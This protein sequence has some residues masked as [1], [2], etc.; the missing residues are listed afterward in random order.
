MKTREERIAQQNKMLAL[1]PKVQEEMC[2][3]YDT[4]VDV[5]IALKKTSGNFLEEICWMVVVSEKKE[6]RDLSPSELIPD[7]IY[8]FRTDV[9]KLQK[10]QPLSDP[11]PA[12]FVAP[13]GLN[14]P[15]KK[16]GNE[17]RPLLGGIQITSNKA[18]PT[19]AQRVAA[20]AAGIPSP[21]V[22]FGTLGCIAIL[23]TDNTPVILTNHHVC[24]P[25]DQ[26]AV[27]DSGGADKLGQPS[28]PRE[29][30]CCCQADYVATIINGTRSL[31]QN[32][33][34][35]GAVGLDAAIARLKG[36]PTGEKVPYTNEIRSIGHL[37]GSN[38]NF[39]VGD[40]VYKHGRKTGYEV[41]YIFCLGLNAITDDSSAI[42]NQYSLPLQIGI[43]APDGEIFSA[44]G[45]SGSV[46]VNEDN[47][48]I[49][50]LHGINSETAVGS[51]HITI[52][53]PIRAVLDFFDITIPTVG[54]QNYIPNSATDVLEPENI[55]SEPVLEGSLSEAF[56][57][58]T[59]TLNETNQGK[60]FIH[61]FTTVKEEILTLINWNREVKVVWNRA[62][63]PAYVGHFIKSLRDGRHRIPKKIG[64]ID[65]TAVFIKSLRV[66]ENHGS[67]F[68]KKGIE[69]KAMSLLEIVQKS[70][71]AEEFLNH[72][73]TQF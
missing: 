30:S 66:F 24:Y 41:G 51:A 32:V 29:E 56:N 17:Y 52:V 47:Q 16:L 26:Q 68:V 60:D 18:V 59:N 55:E 14:A 4:V 45:D 25:N 10:I 6:G 35:I 12:G 36:Y 72:V 40:I 43:A 13:V 2:R 65:R 44:K 21:N 37:N 33:A 19:V 49:G 39:A 64:G 38:D 69:D 11:L 22:K 57:R 28:A 48:V 67:A 70:D 9:E 58:L 20:E 34:G 53:T 1:L 50:L 8:G 31:T 63:G 5:S 54:D 73:K 62:N 7:K 23:N 71:T 42:G 61:L 46:V 3:N 15:R 27:V